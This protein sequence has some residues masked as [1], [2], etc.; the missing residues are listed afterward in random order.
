MNVFVLQ[1][2]DYEPCCYGVF[3][4]LEGAEK[5]ASGLDVSYNHRYVVTKYV[6]NADLDDGMA[7]VGDTNYLDFSP[8]KKIKKWRT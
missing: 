4:S 2:D 8:K 6:L 3:D 5:A 1:A 7:N